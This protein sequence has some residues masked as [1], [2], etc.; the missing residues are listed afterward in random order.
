MLLKVASPGIWHRRRPP[1]GVGIQR[2]ALHIWLSATG[3]SLIF[4][5]LA[6]V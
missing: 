6:G 3:L 5:T 2:L 1:S 4:C